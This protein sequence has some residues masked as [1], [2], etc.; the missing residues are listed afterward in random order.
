[1]CV[2]PLL[3]RSFPWPCRFSSLYLSKFKSCKKKKEKK[4]K[5]LNP[6]PSRCLY[7]CI[8]TDHHTRAD[9][10][11]AC[12]HYIS[13][14]CCSW[15]PRASVFSRPLSIGFWFCCAAAST[16]CC[17]FSPVFSPNLLGNVL[18]QRACERVYAGS[19]AVESKSTTV[20]PSF[21]SVVP[22]AS[23]GFSSPAISPSEPTS[24]FRTLFFF[25][26][27]P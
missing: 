9:L 16:C 5:S 14:L 8:P 7:Y 13:H 12:A 26:A 22:L 24:N 25:S 21:A 3:T 2:F 1:M 20:T 18:M 19:I 27:S 17:V 11:Y 10:I 4:K 23:P 15:S 6:P